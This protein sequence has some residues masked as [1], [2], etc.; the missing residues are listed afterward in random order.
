VLADFF[1]ESPCDIRS[2]RRTPQVVPRRLPRHSDTFAHS[3]SVD[4]MVVA[5]RMQEPGVVEDDVSI[6]SYLYI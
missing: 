6:N 3:F 5:G 2:A 1:R 4:G